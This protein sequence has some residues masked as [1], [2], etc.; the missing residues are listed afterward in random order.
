MSYN[1]PRSNEDDW[2]E[3]F[4]CDVDAWFEA[5]ERGDFRK[6]WDEQQLKLVQGFDP[7]MCDSSED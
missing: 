6:A 3:F 4:D 5:Y 7:P 1:T 2:S